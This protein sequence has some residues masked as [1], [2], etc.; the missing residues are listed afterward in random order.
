MSTPLGAA[1]TGLR[2]LA[3]VVC[4]TAMGAGLY[5]IF[6][7]DHFHCIVYDRIGFPS[8]AEVVVG[9]LRLGLPGLILGA[10]VGVVMAF[11]RR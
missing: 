7:A 6:H 2:L 4:Y 5:V 3:G 8:R 11:L 9:I 1:K 10:L